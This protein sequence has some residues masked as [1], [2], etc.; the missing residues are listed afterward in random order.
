[1]YERL[2]KL[3]RRYVAELDASQGSQFKKL[4]MLF[5]RNMEDQDADSLLIFRNMRKHFKVLSDA[6]M[7]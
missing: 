2:D 4:R 6:Y 3:R 7:L 1:M 5:F